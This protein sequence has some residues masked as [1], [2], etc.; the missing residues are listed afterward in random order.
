MSPRLPWR[1]FVFSV[2]HHAP[3]GS[4]LPLQNTHLRKLLKIGFSAPNRRRSALR[5]DIREERARQS[6]TDDGGGDFYGP[7]WADAKA[8][9]YGTRDLRLAVQERIAVNEKRRALYE[10]LRNGFLAWW[11]ERRRLTNAPVQAG[12][13]QKASFDVQ[14]LAATVKVENVL[15]LTDGSGTCRYVYPYF[16]PDPALTDDAARIGLWLLDQALPNA[17]LEE[18]RILDVIRGRTFSA[19]R[20]PLQGDEEAAFRHMYEALIQE[21]DG[22]SREYDLGAV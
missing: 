6:R 22:L 13:V 15:S 9:A 8:H 12:E 10:Q 21:R 18:I 7:F 1:K 14:G 11:E 4:A 19:G 3:L 2:S 20:T 17:P 5:T 16:A